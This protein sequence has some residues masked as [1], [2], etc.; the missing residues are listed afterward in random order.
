[1]VRLHANGAVELVDLATGDTRWRVEV[2]PRAG[3]APTGAAS[4]DDGAPPIV[5]V[6]EGERRLVGLDLRTGERR[7]R[8]ASKR[9]YLEDGHVFELGKTYIVPGPRIKM[10]SNAFGTVEQKSTAGRLGIFSEV[11]LEGDSTLVRA[12]HI[13][14]GFDGR[15]WFRME[16]R[17]FPLVF[18]PGDR[19]NQLR[20]RKTNTDFMTFEEIR[21]C[22]GSD[23]G[24]RDSKW[25][26][27]PLD[28]VSDGNSTALRLSTERAL[29]Q[30]TNVVD[31][32]EYGKKNSASCDRR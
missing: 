15:V 3:G 1:M 26:L 11:L 24:I 10:P 8:F 22:Y 16:T 2:A 27:L 25:Q 23:I 12:N 9:G 19:I 28:H 18:K 5:V 13:P 20:V 30:K 6:A 7:W 17:A 32:I 21:N 4:A 31:P 29:I 14:A